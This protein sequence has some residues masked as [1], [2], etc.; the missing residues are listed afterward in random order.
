MKLRGGREE[1]RGLERKEESKAG[2]RWGVIIIPI[3]PVIIR[4]CFHT[5]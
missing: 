3:I 1:G 4:L 2:G 5:L